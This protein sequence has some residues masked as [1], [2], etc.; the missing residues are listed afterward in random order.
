M[1][2]FVVACVLLVAA[3]SAAVPAW[4]GPIEVT[5]PDLAGFTPPEDGERVVFEAEAIGEALRAPEE[6]RWVNVLAKD[7]PIGVV[8]E[9]GQARSIT[10]FGDYR[11]NGDTLRIVGI[12]N[13]ACDEHGGDRDVHAES[14]E[15][16][17]IGS[18][19]EH[20]VE[21]WKGVVGLVAGAAGLVGIRLS[22][23][24]RRRY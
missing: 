17:R 2:R 13:L 16:V 20:R 24:R 7:A 1:S 11:R 3:L 5:V 4:A 21:W 15:T 8:M 22:A 6:R 18:L 14:V 23:R 12:F 9:E 19:R 10:H